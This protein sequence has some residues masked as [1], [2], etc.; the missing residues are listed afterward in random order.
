[1]PSREFESHYVAYLRTV[2]EAYP[3][4]VIFAACP[5]NKI[6]YAPAIGAAVGVLRDPKILFLDY[7]TGVISA[8]E[9]CDG[10]HLNPGGAVALA[11]HFAR[12]IDSHLRASG[13]LQPNS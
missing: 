4:A 9:T 6:D 5:H 12:D 8:E 7:S 11:T 2:R 3:A 1:M 10:C 13:A